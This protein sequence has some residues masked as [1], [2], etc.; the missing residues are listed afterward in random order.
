MNAM[1]LQRCLGCAFLVLGMLGCEKSS[2]PAA[3]SAESAESPTGGTPPSAPQTASSSPSSPTSPSAR[4]GIA[5]PIAGK[6]LG[7]N[8]IEISRAD[9]EHTVQAVETYANSG[10]KLAR[11]VLSK[12][13]DGREGMRVF[14]IA[15]N[16]TCGLELGDVVLTIDDVAA[17]NG[18][19]LKEKRGALLQA[20]R[21]VLEIERQGRLQSL[22]YH[23]R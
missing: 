23:V 6:R 14:G 3:T 2:A 1:L 19:S 11:L 18:Q 12:A 21:I 16:A 9:L 15:P 8:E 5:G 20:D 7:A 17:T 4:C 22:T 10:T 13:K